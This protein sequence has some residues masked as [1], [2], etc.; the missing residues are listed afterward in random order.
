MYKIEVRIHLL[1]SFIHS[2]RT[3]V[4]I[5]TINRNYSEN[6]LNDFKINHFLRCIDR[7]LVK[8]KTLNL[9]VKHPA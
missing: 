9:Y 8:V 3:Y 5:L 4:L 7:I 1:H 6:V 2:T